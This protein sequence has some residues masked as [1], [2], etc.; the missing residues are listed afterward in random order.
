[1]RLYHAAHIIELFKLCQRLIE[2]FVYHVKTTEAHQIKRHVEPRMCCQLPIYDLTDSSALG[3]SEAWRLYAPALLE[4]S[5]R[6]SASE[7]LAGRVAS[8]S[9]GAW[10]GDWSYFAD[11]Q[12]LDRSITADSPADFL[13]AG[14]KLVVDDMASRYAVAATAAPTGGVSM[15]V[16]GVNGYRDYAR[17]VAWLE[18]LELVEHANVE[19]VKGSQ[20][21]LRVHARVDATQLAALVELNDQLQPLD[22]L[23][24]GAELGYRWQN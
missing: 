2:Q 23:V 8:L 9:T 12:R 14:V 5:G 18:G 3:T 10:V 22:R 11:G 24:E 16:E 21:L 17:I 19:S 1:M 20:V 6:Y 15:L 7:V 13:N 4:A